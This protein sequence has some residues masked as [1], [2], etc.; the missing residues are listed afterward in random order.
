MKPVLTQEELCQEILR[1][2]KVQGPLAFDTIKEHFDV[3]EAKAGMALGYLET[4]GKV[5][6]N[7]STGYRWGL[8]EK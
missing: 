7:E 8:V 6:A 4:E 1:L 2:L 3:G 5:K